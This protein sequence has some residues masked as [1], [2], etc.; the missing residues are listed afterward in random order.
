MKNLSNIKVGDLVC[1]NCAGMRKKSIGLVTATHIQTT[2]ETVRRVHHFVHIHWAVP[3]SIPPKAEW[4]DPRK[5]AFDQGFEYSKMNK[6][7]AWYRD[8]GHFEVIS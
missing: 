6:M 1:F 8:H 4:G 7:E 2:T 5:M 3:P